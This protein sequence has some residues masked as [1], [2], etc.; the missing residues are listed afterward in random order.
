MPTDLTIFIGVDPGLTGAVGVID[1]D[2]RAIAVIDVITR[3]RTL[4]STTIKREFDVRP[5][6]DQ[7]TDRLVNYLNHEW[8]ACI[9]APFSV[10][11][12]NMMGTCSLFQTYGGLLAMLE[13]IGIDVTTVRPGEWK[14]GFGLTKDKDYSITVARQ[15]W[16]TI[17]LDA[18]RHHNRAEALLIAEYGRLLWQREQLLATAARRSSVGA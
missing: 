16:P 15:M 7:L 8:R 13:M 9:E 10:P 4:T 3:R 5:T 14:R 12:G 17:N 6:V 11:G 1:Q 2:S 18:K